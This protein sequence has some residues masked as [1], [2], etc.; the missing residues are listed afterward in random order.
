MMD[1]SRSYDAVVIGAGTAGLTAGIRLA[2]AGARVCVVAKGF[3]STHLAPGWIDVLSWL[4]AD[5]PPASARLVKTPGEAIERL[6][7][8]SP[9]HPYA[10]L[11]VKL[12]G[13]ALDWFM[14]LAASGPLPGYR[15]EG[16]LG[17]NLLLPTA[18]GALRPTAAAPETFLA[19][20]ASGL[21]RLVVV[22]TPALRDFHPRLCAENLRASGIDARAAIVE[23]TADRADA[24]ATGF[25]RR[26]DDPTSRAALIARLAPV[27]R[28]A[29][30]VALPA[31]LGLRDPHSVLLDV[32]QQLG[33]RVFEIPTL[34]PSVPGMR[35]YELLRAALQAAGGHL[36]LGA[37]VI[38]HDR[39][40]ERVRSV[41]TATAGSPT[42]Y[43]ADHFLL[44]AGGFHS[45]A[46]A[47]D[48]NWQTSERIFGLPLAG[49][50]PLGQPRFVADY[51]A[52]QPISRVGVAV[53]SELRSAAAENVLVAGA[54]LPGAAPWREGSGEGIA[55]ASG[56]RVAQVITGERDSASRA[57]ASGPAPAADEAEA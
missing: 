44:A 16:G 17:G 46:I 14:S 50:P 41:T 26:F 24:S 39:T 54:S 4:P 31:I 56:Y 11:G 36:A 9:E 27:V 38:D 8:E 51:F 7:A 29:D 10:L 23:L 37:G 49:V 33:R 55:L 13:E 43:M 20:E 25:A 12:V 2:Q 22:G 40:G 42:T 30:Q 47:I 34:P 3:G 19:G 21:R 35:L 28:G 57:P 45:G 53:D 32:E 1:R 5:G 52:E 48:S 18:V 15:Y 6:V